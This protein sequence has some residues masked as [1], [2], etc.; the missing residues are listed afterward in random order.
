MVVFFEASQSPFTGERHVEPRPRKIPTHIL[1]FRSSLPTTDKRQ[2]RLF[3][4]KSHLP[5]YMNQQIRSLRYSPL[6]L[7]APRP[8]DGIVRKRGTNK[9][10]IQT[11]NTP[12]ANPCNPALQIER[13][14]RLA[15]AIAP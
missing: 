13:E 3:A 9:Q 2:S 12:G 11:F 8:R 7:C 6:D 4:R 5:N 1:T 14:V 15:N 10:K